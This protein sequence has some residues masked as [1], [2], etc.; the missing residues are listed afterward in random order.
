MLSLDLVVCG[1]VRL[2][3]DMYLYEA[4]DDNVRERKITV[5]WRRLQFIIYE[6]CSKRPATKEIKNAEATYG[7]SCDKK[8][9][10]ST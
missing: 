6:T 4:E 7:K 1:D 9:E 8:H 2:D 5:T 10:S 3:K